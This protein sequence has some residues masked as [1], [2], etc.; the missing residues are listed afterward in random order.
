MTPAKKP[1]TPRETPPAIWPF[2]TYKGQ[3]LPKRQQQPMT[4]EPARW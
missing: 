3:P 2:P 4:Q 1:T